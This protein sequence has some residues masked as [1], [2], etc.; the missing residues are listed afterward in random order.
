MKHV[1]YTCDFCGKKI[2]NIHSD[3]FCI[4]GY[5]GVGYVPQLDFH[6][7]SCAENAIK[8]LNDGTFVPLA[9]VVNVGPVPDGKE[10]A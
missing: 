5:G 6:T 7:G 8:G 2:G 9:S 1:V 3:G 4:N 10:G